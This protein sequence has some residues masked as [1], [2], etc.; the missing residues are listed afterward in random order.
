[1]LCATLPYNENDHVRIEKDRCY[2]Y[3]II[4]KTCCPIVVSVNRINSG[5]VAFY[6]EQT[7]EGKGS[8]SIVLPSD[9]IYVVKGVG[10]T[11][12]CAIL[13]IVE[14]VT[15]TADVMQISVFDIGVNDI[16]NAIT[17]VSDSVQSINAYN[18]GVD[19]ASTVGTATNMLNAL[20]AY[21]TATGANYIRQF[22]APGDAFTG[23]T[24]WSDIYASTTGYRLLVGYVGAKMNTFV[25]NGVTYTPVAHAV[26]YYL[27]SVF[28][29]LPADYDYITQIRVA[30]NELMVCPE[31]YEW[32]VEEEL[33]TALSL[34]AAEIANYGTTFDVPGPDELI[35]II[36]TNAT[37]PTLTITVSTGTIE[38]VNIDFCTTLWEFC[39]LWDCM[40]TKIAEWLC[41]QDPC[42]PAC[43]NPPSGA[44]YLDLMLNLTLYGMFPLLTEHHIWQFGNLSDDEGANLTRLKPTNLLWD[45][46]Y[47]MIEGCGCAPGKNCECGE[48]GITRF[49]P[50]SPIAQ[51]PNCKTCG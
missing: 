42:A 6:E 13:T 36:L 24:G 26:A 50:Q 15:N 17:F 19:G 8:I 40:Q 20:D 7:L 30:G 25:V 16:A 12:G 38:T 1:M 35:G 47:K 2:N 4:N 32:E 10:P 49:L 39:K 43:P 45:R 46:W 29:T 41:C 18:S 5:S 51:T 21:G 33:D 27:D 48:I 11:D 9:G 22:K 37:Y 34:A 28:A 3:R 31:Y 14:S 44:D 23:G